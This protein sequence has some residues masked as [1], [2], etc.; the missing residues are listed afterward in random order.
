M[1]KLLKFM[2]AIA[3][4][5]LLLLALPNQAE[6]QGGGEERYFV[7]TG[8]TVDNDAI[9]DY[10]QSRGGVNTFGYPASPQVEW[11]GFQVQVFQRHV[12][13]QIG[14]VVRPINL[15]DPDVMPITT[16][17]GLSFPAYDEGLAQSAPAI[18]Q[19]QYAESVQ[20][21]IANTVT[22]EWQGQ[23]VGFLD[24]F[25]A[26]APNA[27]GLEA[28]LIALEVWGFPTSQP[29]PDPNNS[30]FVYQRFQRGIMHYDATEGVTAGILLGDAFKGELA[31]ELP[32]FDLPKVQVDGF[33]LSVIDN[34]DVDA[35]VHPTALAWDSDGNLYVARM[36]GEIIKIDSAG[37]RSL[38]ADG[39]DL[40]L[41]LAFRPG[42]RDLYVSQRGGVT[43]LRD[44]NGDGL[45][46]SKT[47]F[48]SDLHCCYAELHQT[49]GIQFG[50]DGWLYV[51]QGSNSDHG[52]VALEPFAGGILRADPAVGQDSLEYVAD[53]L[54]N[55]YDLTVRSDG[56]IF[57]TDNGADYG[58]PEELNH[59]IRGQNYGWPECVTND[60]LVV[61]P[62]PTWNDPAQC[63]GTRAAI[64][65]FVP[66]ASANGLTAYEADQFPADYQGDLFVVLWSHIEGAYRMVHV[67]LTPAG[68]SFST[69]VN[70]FVLDLDLPLAVAVGP[71]GALYIAD[72]GPGVL[73]KV[74]YSG[75]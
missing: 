34:S 4:L 30:S 75:E 46:E 52:E 74:S 66:H 28:G 70:D 6:A 73:Y 23:P 59:I 13:Q 47:P 11:R 39:F 56:Q 1:T 29:T 45:A 16:F 25:Y 15:L 53:G 32:L 14:D 44:I 24:Y 57:A 42:T 5:S 43:I 20:Q 58:P 62:H 17:G 38:Y 36:E 9:W 63:V 54:R 18:D 37:N 31:D 7:E 27:Q 60:A 48:L 49:N 21:H 22:N 65:T 40:P 51:A 41:G 64:A 50:P 8:W 33:E 61:E 26:A 35:I 72:W 10:F 71:D 69:V 67:D 19:Q 12:L 3:L 55:P 2:G 68:D